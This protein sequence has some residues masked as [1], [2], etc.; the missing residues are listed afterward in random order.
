MKI[1]G[2]A[3]AAGDCHQKTGS[4]TEGP[5]DPNTS[6]GQGTASMG[7]SRALLM[8]ARTL[9]RIEGDHDPQRAAGR[10]R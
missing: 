3:G 6:I 10:Q 8:G 1:G 7:L 2:I 4:I 9:E 5:N